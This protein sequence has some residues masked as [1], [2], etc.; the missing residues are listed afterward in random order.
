MSDE[1]TYQEYREVVNTIAEGIAEEMRAGDVTDQGDAVH[2]ACDSHSW[3]IYTKYKFAIL[4]H[5][6]NSDAYTDDFGEV[7]T[8]GGGGINWAALAYAALAQAVNEALSRL[9]TDETP[10]EEEDEEEEDEDSDGTEGQDRESYT[11]NQDRESY[12]LPTEGK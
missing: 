11:D 2:E 5:C 8:V 7:P 6:S 3:V 12:T 9:D 1:T 10:E 4:L